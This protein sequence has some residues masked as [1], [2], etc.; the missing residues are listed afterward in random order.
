MPTT[1][2]SLF[3]SLL[4]ILQVCV[5]ALA[6]LVAGGGAVYFAFAHVLDAMPL[7]DLKGAFRRKPKPG[8]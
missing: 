7:G 2:R 8:K 6:G 4:T 1:T 5:L 3:R